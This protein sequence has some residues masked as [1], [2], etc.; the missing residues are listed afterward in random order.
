MKSRLLMAAIL[1]ALP[2][3]APAQSIQ[4]L[5]NQPPDGAELTFQLTDGTVLAQGYGNDDFWVLTPDNTGSYVNGTW[6]QVGSLQAGYSPSANASQVLADGRVLFEGGEYNPAGNFALTNQGAIY[7]PIKQTW[8][9]VNPPKGWQNIGDSPSVVL[10]NGNFLLGDK[11]NEK[12]AE[13]NPKNMKWKEVKSKGKNDF[14]AEEG[15]TLMPDGSVLTFD[16][17][18]NP[19]SEDYIASE[20]KWLSLGSTVANLQGPP[21]CGCI[22]YPPKNKCYYPPGEVGPAVL[23]PNGT[24]FA[25]GATHSGESTAHTAVYTPGSGWA[26][27]PDFPN[28]DQAG[29]SFSTLLTN[30]EGMVEGDSGRLYT[31][32][33]TSLTDTKMN[34]YGVLMI[35]PNGQILI[36]GSE[37]YNSAG[38]YQA[39]WQP[40]IS[41]FPSSVTRGDTYQISGTQFNGLSQTGGGMGDEYQT[42]TN[43]PLVQITN[44]SSKHVFYARTHDHSTM[45]VA[46]GSQSVSTNFDVPSGME[47]GASSLVV[48]A[49]GIPSSAVSVMVQ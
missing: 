41:T 21:C 15:W 13:L 24:V 11:L 6:K 12:M 32:D 39:A 34:G 44:N 37:V 33:G 19:Q 5:K 4:Q 49:N 30:G 3:V 42:S 31:W 22:N 36:S 25:T 20:G 29:D 16:V 17:K 38:T 10:P 47:T 35:L 27:G 7:D 8:T 48:I 1:A 28:N 45:G 18:D 14:N 23:M 26:A 9:A 46:T 2:G 40:T 43:Y